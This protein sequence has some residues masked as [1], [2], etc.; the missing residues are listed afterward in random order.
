MSSLHGSAPGGPVTRRPADQLDARILREL[1]RD[2]Q[3]TLVA[4]AQRLGISRNTVQARITRLEAGGNLLPHSTRVDPRALGYPIAAVVVVTVRQ[5][6][7]ST[8]TDALSVLPEVLEVLVLAGSMD[9]LVHVAATDAD[10]LYRIT[11]CVQGMTGVVRTDTSMVMRRLVDRRV[12]PLLD[13]LAAGP[14]GS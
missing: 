12:A 9:L 13:R 14:A 10:D 8:V 3:S 2:P 6:Q 4:L 7:L 1:D 5:Q 11:G